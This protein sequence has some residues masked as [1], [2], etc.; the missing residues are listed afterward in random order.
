MAIG[1]K[2]QQ[3]G[4]VCYGQQ[5]PCCPWEDFLG[6][7]VPLFTSPDTT[8]R[9]PP[10]NMLITYMKKAAEEIMFE[11]KW[12]QDEYCGMLQCGVKELPL[13]LPEYQK[14][15]GVVKVKVQGCDNPKYTE[16]D[17]IVVLRDAPPYDIEDG[18]VI[19]YAYS[20]ILD[21]CFAPPE[22]CSTDTRFREL[23]LTIV[24]R[25]MYAMLGMPWGN[26]TMYQVKKREAEELT[27]GLRMDAKPK[28][29][30]RVRL[31]PHIRKVFWDLL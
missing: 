17:C 21:D 26:A 7:V 8:V 3:P 19:T 20:Y 14:F 5:K 1:D 22:F 12:W 16:G 9:H 23:M 11:T 6:Y 15:I 29:N 27:D 2:W 13:I 30:V 25:D 24:Q 4:P 31:S 28:T 10:R 18:Y